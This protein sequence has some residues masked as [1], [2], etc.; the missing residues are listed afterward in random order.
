MHARMIQVTTKPGQV[1]DLLKIMIDRG[2]PLLK[3]QWGF[4]DA[5]ALTSDTQLDE[6]VGVSIWK[7]RE[8]AEKYANGPGRQFL[9]TL[10][11]MLIQEPSFR[12]FNV[13]AST[14]H[15]VGIAR[16]ASSA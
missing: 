3:Q 16:A 12:S 1:K 2:V 6:F 11:P 13:D 5:V 15:K 10:K 8:D 7:S 4:I 14:F 9:E